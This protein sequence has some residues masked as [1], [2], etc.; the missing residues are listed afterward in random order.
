MDS[1]QW[2][3]LFHPIKY[4]QWHQ[5]I[6]RQSLR[7]VKPSNSVQAEIAALKRGSKKDAEIIADFQFFADSW[8]G[9]YFHDLP[10]DDN[11]TRAHYTLA[12][13]SYKMGR[14]MQSMLEG[15]MEYHSIHEVI[16]TLCDLGTHPLI[17]GTD[18]Y[19][20]RIAFGELEETTQQLK[21]R[22]QL[23]GII[24]EEEPTSKWDHIEYLMNLEAAR[25]YRKMVASKSVNF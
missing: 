15:L 24:L 10:K 12:A 2:E 1:I 19:C 3:Q 13:E 5:A 14:E 22:L 25:D 20:L 7:I 21:E 11:T 6:M 23:L 4:P 16:A 17:P 9:Q 18:F 8:F